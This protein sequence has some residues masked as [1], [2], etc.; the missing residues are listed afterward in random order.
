M[1]SESWL[2]YNFLIM[3][4][5]KIVA[6]IYNRLIKPEAEY[7]AKEGI[8]WLQSE[9]IVVVDNPSCFDNSIDVVVVYGG[10][11]SL[12]HVANMVTEYDIPIMGI[13]CGRVGYLCS[14]SSQ[15]R[16]TILKSLFEGNAYLDIRHRVSV[17]VNGEQKLDALNEIA[18]GGIN[19]TVYLDLFMK[20][21]CTL[22]LKA[23]GDGIIVSTMTG[24]TA[25]NVNAGGPVMFSDN[26]FSV[27][28]NN[29]IFQ[30]D[31]LPVN[32]KSI[33]TSIDTI[34]DVEITNKD[35]NNIPDLI[36]DGQRIYELSKH[37]E[38]KIR[39]SKY[40]TKLIKMLNEEET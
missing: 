28:A 19:R 14:S 38:I 17:F 1:K 13:N 24:S 10:D 32:T 31:S 8:K 9:G 12:L 30:S 29:S 27:V 36:A 37:D 20:H 35:K 18:I 4:D 39:K 25:Y 5:I 15:N 2:R 11:G 7:Y 34:F 23:I 16:L 6:A 3:K 40:K 26:V 33:V 22:K 21:S